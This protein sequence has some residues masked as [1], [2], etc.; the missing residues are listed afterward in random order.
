M[1]ADNNLKWTIELQEDPDTGD[2]ILEF[3]PEMLAK[4]GWQEGDTLTWRELGDG[5]WTLEKTAKTD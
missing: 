5:A 3:P 4:T 1:D 2:A